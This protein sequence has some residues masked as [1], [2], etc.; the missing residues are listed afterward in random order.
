MS[1][2]DDASVSGSGSDR[3]DADLMDEVE[4][5]GDNENKVNKQSNK[6]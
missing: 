4:E 1:D 2:Y 5:T 3:D 6:Q